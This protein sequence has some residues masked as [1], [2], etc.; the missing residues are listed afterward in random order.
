ML[1]YIITFCMDILF[2]YNFVHK[3]T[4]LLGSHL[5]FPYYVKQYSTVMHMK[6]L[7]AGKN[8]V[9][10]NISVVGLDKNCLKR[11]SSDD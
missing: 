7:H 5:S 9:R 1:L 2:L 6:F 8:T 4:S 10:N 11:L 3:I